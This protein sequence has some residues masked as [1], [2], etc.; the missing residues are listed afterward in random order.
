MLRKQ[1]I[2]FT[3][4]VYHVMSRGNHQEAIFLEDRD[5]EIFLDTLEEVCSRTYTEKSTRIILRRSSDW[6]T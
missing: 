5:R 2:E 3:W 4:A 6:K 1:R